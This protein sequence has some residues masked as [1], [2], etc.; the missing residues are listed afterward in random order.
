MLRHRNTP[1]YGGRVGARRDNQ[2]LKRGFVHSLF[3]SFHTSLYGMF[4]DLMYQLHSAPD[5]GE[6]LSGIIYNI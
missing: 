1:P 4:M 6:D 2:T 5:P 3:L